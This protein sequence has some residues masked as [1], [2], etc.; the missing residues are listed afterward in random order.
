MS[1]VIAYI[2]ASVN[3]QSAI[4]ADPALWLDNRWFGAKNDGVTD[5]SKANQAMVAFAINNM[6]GVA[7]FFIAGHSVFNDPLLLA[8]MLHYSMNGFDSSYNIGY[9]QRSMLDYTGGAGTNGILTGGI[10]GIEWRNVAIRYSNPSFDG[11]L[12]YGFGSQRI[13]FYSSLIRAYSTYTGHKALVF[14]DQA[15]TVAFHDCMG[16]GDRVVYGKSSNGS[17]CNQLLWEGGYLQGRTVEPLWNP[18]TAW[19]VRDTVIESIDTTK[20]PGLIN[21]DAGFRAQGLSVLENWM[22]DDTAVGSWVTFE[23]SGCTVINGITTTTQAGSSIVKVNGTSDDGIEVGG[24]FWD[25]D[26]NAFAIDTTGATTPKV[27]KVDKM[28]YNSL[29]GNL[30]NGVLPGGSMLWFPRQQQMWYADASV[31]GPIFQGDVAGRFVGFRRV[32]GE[33]SDR[34]RNRADGLDFYGD[35]TG[36]FDLNTSRNLSANAGFSFASNGGLM[37]DGLNRIRFHTA[38][39]NGA[40]GGEVGDVCFVRNGA[41]GNWT[42]QCVTAGAPGVAVWTPYA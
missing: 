42:F 25:C 26:V 36:L 5:D 41:P 40:M 23:G 10:D 8:G 32:A 19:T 22:G 37:A 16:Y 24:G 35:G 11:W 7:N 15:T 6:G 33:T 18:G 2:P 14:L 27:L 30:V 34:M 29:P 31:L 13:K 9:Y 3:P 38:N 39:P 28:G 1:E 4:I 20:K 21:H 17:Y 12:W